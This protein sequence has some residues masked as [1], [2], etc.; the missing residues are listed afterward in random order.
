MFSPSLALFFDSAGAGEWLV[1]FVVVLIVVG[2]KR[3]PAVARKLGHLTE[4]FRRA[5]DEFKRQLLS[6]DEEPAPLPPDSPAT[7]SDGVPLTGPDADGGAEEPYS[8]LPEDDTAEVPGDEGQA[9][10]WSSDDL[11]DIPPES[12]TGEENPSLP[13]DRAAAESAMAE[14]SVSDAPDMPS[15]SANPTPGQEG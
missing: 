1:L 7:D 12:D 3:L 2:P 5:A 8:S 4:M 15:P 14:S 10:Q 11:S 9:R 6:M 13:E